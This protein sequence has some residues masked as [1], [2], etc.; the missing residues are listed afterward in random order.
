MAFLHSSFAK[1][2]INPNIVDG[3][4]H[5]TRNNIFDPTKAG[6]FF[7][8]A[9]VAAAFLGINALIS[10]GFS[11]A[12]AISWLKAITLLLILGVFFTGSK[13]GVLLTILLFALLIITPKII[14]RQLTVQRVLIALFFLN[15]ILALA[16]MAMVTLHYSDFVRQSAETIGVRITIWSYGFREFLH[17]PLMG[18]GFGGWQRGFA[19][20]AAQIDINPN[21]PPHNTLIYLWAESGL[22]TVILALVFMF[23]I[24]KFSIQ[25]IKSRITDLTMLGIA[26]LGAYSWTFIHGM[27][28]NFGL[29]GELHME[30]VLAALLGYSL[31]HCKS[32][33]ARYVNVQKQY[34][35]F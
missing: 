30:I 23:T 18:L 22:V 10:Y 27:G 11:K 4:F 3:L 34:H 1:I 15:V 16:L 12:Y 6:G 14:D 26:L 13:A 28:T 20:Y 17:H 2:L 8:N 25:L 21:F 7:T 5:G 9:N 33:S 19:A 32:Y 29:V 35:H 31:S 24:L